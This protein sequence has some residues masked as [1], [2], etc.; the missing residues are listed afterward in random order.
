MTLG[1]KV[2][3]LQKTATLL[4]ERVDN[5][6]KSLDALYEAHKETVRKVTD[7]RR[8]FERE[9]AL[10]KREIDDFK[11]WKDDQKKERDEWSRK[12]WS[13]GPNAVGAL[14]SILGAA[15]V[16]YFISRR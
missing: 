11:K 12:L 13:F 3:E 8:D 4:V 14:I 2:D 7:L 6:L 10:L 9:I 5:A 15:A 1:E 16:A